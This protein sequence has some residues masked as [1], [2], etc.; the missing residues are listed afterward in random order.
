MSNIRHQE[1]DDVQASA[2]TRIFSSS[3]V[4]QLAKRGRSPLFARLV[5]ESGLIETTC[6]E[7]V[8]SFFD[9][10]FKAL[11][12]PG[13]RSEHFYK[14]ALFQKILLGRHS[15]RTAT[16]LTEIRVANHRA[17]VLILN[18]SSTA[19]EVKSERDDLQKLSSQIDTYRRAFAQVS[20]I[21]DDRHVNRILRMVPNDVGVLRISTRRS[22]SIEQDS[23]ASLDRVEPAVIYDILRRNEAELVLKNSGLELPDV[24]NS[25]AYGVLR[26]MFIRLDP[27]QAHQGMVQVLQ[28]SRSLTRL[29]DFLRDVPRSLHTAALTVRLSRCERFRLTEALKAPMAEAVGWA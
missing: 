10:A 16:M 24:P 1:I 2:I 6:S 18:G 21:A 3:V 14:T 23:Q 29:E 8:A 19:Y 25:K 28:R 22:I 11:D 5:R 12:R 4:R 15:L 20:V 7:S 17:D 13:F 27:L 26:E 9:S